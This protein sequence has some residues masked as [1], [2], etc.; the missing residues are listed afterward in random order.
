M[1]AWH[2]FALTMLVQVT[3]LTVVAA[4]ATGPRACSRAALRHAIGVMTLSLVL[5]SPALALLLPRTFWMGGVARLAQAD[6]PP[7]IDRPPRHSPAATTN[8]NSTPIRSLSPDP[9]IPSTPPRQRVRARHAAVPLAIF[10]PGSPK[11]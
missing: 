4:I 7:R 8:R 9:T 3:A 11:P 6:E 2:G 1:N 10:R 5:A